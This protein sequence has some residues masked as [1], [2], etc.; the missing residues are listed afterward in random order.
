MMATLQGAPG[1]PMWEALWARGRYEHALL[2]MVGG[3]AAGFILSLV[4]H[5][6]D[7]LLLGAKATALGLGLLALAMPLL[8]FTG[9]ARERMV[10]GTVLAT[11]CMA[12]GSYVTT[13]KVWVTLV[14][15]GLA[16][17]GTLR[18]YR[19]Y[20][21]TEFRPHMMQAAIEKARAE[22]APKTQES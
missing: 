5:D 12:V 17:A 2:W 8:S 6:K 3:L 4:M 19:I 9:W 14:S 21:N 13:Q 16:L 18:G 10:L 20:H 15:T 11:L 1:D 22:A 7:A